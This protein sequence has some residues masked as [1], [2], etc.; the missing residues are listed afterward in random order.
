MS[1]QIAD[2]VLLQYTLGKTV[3]QGISPFLLFAFDAAVAA[4]SCVVTLLKY[5]LCVSVGIFLR[6]ERVAA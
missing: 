1:V 6:E 4:S 3:E 5:A 2:G